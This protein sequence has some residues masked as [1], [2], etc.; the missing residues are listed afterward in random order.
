MHDYQPGW[1]YIAARNAKNVA[2][3]RVSH[4]ETFGMVLSI[5]GWTSD[6]RILLAWYALFSIVTFKKSASRSFELC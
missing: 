6:D 1:S 2:S 4:V 3:R 5:F